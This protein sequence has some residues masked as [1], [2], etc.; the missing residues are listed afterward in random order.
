MIY[1]AIKLGEKDN[2]KNKSNDRKFKVKGK[3]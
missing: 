3:E 2:E 1:N